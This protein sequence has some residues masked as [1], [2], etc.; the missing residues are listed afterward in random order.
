MQLNNKSCLYC[1]LLILLMYLRKKTI[2]RLV[3]KSM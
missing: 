2:F 3:F 1:H